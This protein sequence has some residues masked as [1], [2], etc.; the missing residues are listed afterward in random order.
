MAAVGR[1]DRDTPLSRLRTAAARRDGFKQMIAARRRYG[2]GSALLIEITRLAADDLPAW[3]SSRAA[4]WDGS[5]G[6]FTSAAIIR[7]VNSHS[8]AG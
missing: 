2:T 3:G 1:G 7:A 4:S 6:A 8:P 5:R